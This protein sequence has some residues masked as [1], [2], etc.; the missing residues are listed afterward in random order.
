MVHATKPEVLVLDCSAIPD[1]EYT[2]LKMLT[3]ADEKLQEQGITLWLAAPNSVLLSAIERA[4]LGKALG[5][6]RLFSS[7]RQAL[8][9]YRERRHQT[10]Y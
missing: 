8:A 9:A 1:I 7:L 2:A 10:E 6:R 5:D 3:E 4:P